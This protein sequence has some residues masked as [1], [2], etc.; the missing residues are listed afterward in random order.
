[1]HPSAK[2][3]DGKQV[4]AEDVKWTFETLIDKGHPYYKSYYAD[5]KN[6]EIINKNSVKF[7]FLSSTNRELPLIIGQ[8]QIL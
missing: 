7:N 5:I 2:W 4:T 1:M 8:M 6:V 3:S